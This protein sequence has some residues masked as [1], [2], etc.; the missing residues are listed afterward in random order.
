LDGS[1]LKYFFVFLHGKQWHKGPWYNHNVWYSQN[2][3][4]F[5]QLSTQTISQEISKIKE[6]IKSYEADLQAAKQKDDKE[7]V[8]LL[9]E[10]IRTKKNILLSKE[11]ILISEK[12]L[13]IKLQEKE[14]LPIANNKGK[15]FS[16]ILLLFN[17]HHLF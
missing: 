1:L 17:H 10:Y 14:N 9:R 3:L 7:E 4:Q 6:R 15:I 16:S 11:N 5:R 8:K 2:K 12:N 13:L